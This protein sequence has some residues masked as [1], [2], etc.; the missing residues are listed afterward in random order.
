MLL[1]TIF[2]NKKGF[3]VDIGAHHP[4]RFSNTYYFYKIGWNGINIDAMPGSM[5]I[6]NKIRPRD[7][8]LEIAI[9]ENIEE[10][11]YYAF[12]EPAFNGF[13]KNE[14]V[15]KIK[16]DGYNLLFS[17]KIKTKTLAEVLN[18]YLK[19][20]SKIDFMSIDVEGLD[21]EVLQSNDW[22]RYKPDVLLVEIHKYGLENLKNHKI[23]EFISNK[24]YELICSTINTFIFKKKG[25]I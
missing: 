18:L 8:N 25:L 3:Y 15:G 6:F 24:E 5:H 19:N 12:N 20:E 14:S 13:L 7:V 4:K 22:D 1:R 9:S 2:R 23:Y 21:L 17:R 16:K 11:D 10:L